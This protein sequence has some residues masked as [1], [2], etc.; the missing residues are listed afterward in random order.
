MN[1][2]R[3]YWKDARIKELE[4]HRDILQDQFSQAMELVRSWRASY[5]K[6]THSVLRPKK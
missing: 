3:C 6:L 4:E 1:C 5:Q 2:R